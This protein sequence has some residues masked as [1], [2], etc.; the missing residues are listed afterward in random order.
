[1]IRKILTAIRSILWGLV[2]GLVSRHAM[3]DTDTKAVPRGFADIEH[4]FNICGHFL[5]LTFKRF[6]VAFVAFAAHGFFAVGIIL[7]IVL[8]KPIMTTAGNPIP[9]YKANIRDTDNRVLGV[10]TDRYRVVQ[11]SEAFAFTDAFFV[12]FVAFAAHGFF[13]VGIILGIVGFAAAQGLAAPDTIG[14]ILLGAVTAWLPFT[15][16][17]Q[18]DSP[19][20]AADQ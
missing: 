12:A 8:Q 15:R 3:A 19:P 4:G 17:H 2:A 10:V 14:V 6:F 9:G 11:N 13:A 20:G 18:Q 1:M 5:F 16:R 7:G